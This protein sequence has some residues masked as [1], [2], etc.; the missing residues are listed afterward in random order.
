[1][2]N[3]NVLRSDLRSAIRNNIKTVSHVC[4]VVGRGPWLANDRRGLVVV[5]A[6]FTRLLVGCG[7][8]R[9]FILYFLYS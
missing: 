7:V 8:V 9:D 5:A 2:E 6:V 1:M 3:K 4:G